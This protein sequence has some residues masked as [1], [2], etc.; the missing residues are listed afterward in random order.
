MR[1]ILAWMS[2]REIAPA[3]VA[4]IEV[5]VESLLEH[6]PALTTAL[7]ARLLAWVPGLTAGRASSAELEVLV[8]SLIG[9]VTSE[10][11]NPHRILPCLR[12]LALAHLG[13]AYTGRQIRS[14]RD[15][16][17]CSIRQCLGSQFDNQTEAA[18]YRAMEVLV[19][20]LLT[21]DRDALPV[22]A[23]LVAEASSGAWA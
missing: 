8:M 2:Q 21:P 20:Q 22:E 10:L 17:I 4:V 23:G 7:F 14:V 12:S 1:P 6:A 16:L 18:W 15:A 9:M 5:T 13:P 11:P 19:E 3:D